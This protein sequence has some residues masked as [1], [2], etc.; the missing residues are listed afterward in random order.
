[1]EASNAIRNGKDRIALFDN[2]KA[3]LIV[4][5]VVGHFVDQITSEY[6]SMRA[7][8]IFIYTFHMPLFLFLSGLMHRPYKAGIPFQRNRFISFILVYL[9]YKVVISVTQLILNGE[10]SFSL[11]SA[12]GIPWFMFTLAAYEL[13]AY[14]IQDVHPAILLPISVLVSMF[15]G[16]DSSVKDYLVLSRTVVFLP[17]FLAGYYLKPEQILKIAGKWYVKLISALVAVGYALLC[18]FRTDTV[19]KL[20]MLFTGRNPFSSIANTIPSIGAPFRLLALLLS[21]TVGFAILCAAPN[22]RIKG[23]T[24]MGNRTLQPYFWHRPL[25]Y[26]IEYFA[27]FEWM[28][29][30]LGDRAAVILFV[31]MAIALTVV[32]SLPVFRHPI[33]EILGVGKQLSKRKRKTEEKVSAQSASERTET[34]TDREQECDR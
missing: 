3:F 2:V 10:T 9:A 13:I 11:L 1:M 22:I 15:V 27:C 28:R 34:G 7:V 26:V 24:A 14:L 19:Y 5:V 21:A 23:I 29:N 33:S 30:A 18:W 32:L 12:S 6:T 17:F 20:R 31:L 4:C 16:L 8:F 25:L